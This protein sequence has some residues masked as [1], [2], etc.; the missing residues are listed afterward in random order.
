M[1]SKPSKRVYITVCFKKRK[2]KYKLR[3]NSRKKLV[4]SEIVKACNELVTC[5]EQG[6]RGTSIC[7]QSCWNDENLLCP[8]WC[9]TKKKA[10][11][12]Q[13]AEAGCYYKKY[14]GVNPLPDREG[15]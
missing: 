3:K 12:S 5:K 11:K 6:C 4:S 8:T 15:K 10:N 14:N 13:R 9:Q 1:R 2:K 7:H